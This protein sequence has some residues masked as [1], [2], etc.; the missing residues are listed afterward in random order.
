[1][2]P[3]ADSATAGKWLIACGSVA[4][5]G[6][7]WLA[8][9]PTSNR[10]EHVLAFLSLLAALAVLG[11]IAFRLAQACS[12][13][14]VT[15][16]GLLFAAAFRLALVPAGLPSDGFLA[17]L[18]DD[19]RS[20]AVVYERFLLYDNDT[21]RYLWDGQVVLHG[22]SPWRTSPGDFDPELRQGPLAES[23]W[24]DVWGYVDFRSHRS[25]YPPLTQALFAAQVALAGS[26]L[27]IW[28]LLLTGIDLLLVWG[29]FRGLAAAGSP[30]AWGLLYAWNPVVV[31]ELV[32]SAHV[33]GWMMVWCVAAVLLLARGRPASAGAALAAAALAKLAAIPLAVLLLRRDRWRGLYALA[34]LL[35]LT[36]LILRRDLVAYLGAFQAYWSEWRFNSGIWEL[37]AGA[38]SL[39][40]ASEPQLWADLAAKAALVGVALAIWRRDPEPTTTSLARAAFWL[41]ALLALTSP[42]VM[43]WYLLWAAPFAAL[44]GAVTWY[45]V[46]VL[47]LSSYLVYAGLGE[48]WWWRVAEHVLIA[49]LLCWELRRGAQP[50]ICMKLAKLP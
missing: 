1:M 39:L 18:A 29:L 45:P 28:K 24:R 22:A 33:D 48:A 16:A 20:R 40:G 13:R 11:A 27:F 43:P 12:R 5:L 36:A 47:S 4:L 44:A 3:P 30:P 50:P 26:S 2:A 42:A 7:L 10:L 38:A 23:I 41:L 46:T 25:V 8:F 34:G 49:L 35:G 31:K 15:R 6:Y 14:L 21:W 9:L 37:L 17:A 32:G 19:V